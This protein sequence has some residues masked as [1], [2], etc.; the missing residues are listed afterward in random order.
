MAFPKNKLSNSIGKA[1]AIPN[2]SLQQVDTYFIGMAYARALMSTARQG[3]VDERNTKY[4]CNDISKP[5]K[6]R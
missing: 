3:E 1:K 2:G 6:S 5:A 4:Q